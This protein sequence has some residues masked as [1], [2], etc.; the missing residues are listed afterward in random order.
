MYGMGPLF[1]V[2]GVV[3]VVVYIYLHTRTC[4]GAVWAPFGVRSADKGARHMI[5]HEAR[6][7]EIKAWMSQDRF[8]RTVCV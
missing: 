5:T 3:M 7:K 8:K 2:S 1:R 4:T 6:V